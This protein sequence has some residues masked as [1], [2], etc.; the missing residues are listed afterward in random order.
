MDSNYNNG[1][2]VKN[3]DNGNKGLLSLIMGIISILF[4]CGVVGII[5][6]IVAIV[7]GSENKRSDTK[8]K[9]GLV[10]GIIGTILSV[11]G[12]IV[13]IIVWAAAVVAGASNIKEIGTTTNSYDYDLYNYDT[14][15]NS[16]DYNDTEEAYDSTEDNG[17]AT[18][19]DKEQEE[20]V[21][22]TNVDGYTPE[23]D[24]MLIGSDEVGYTYVPSNFI[25]FTEAGGTGFD[26]TVQYAY[27]YEI[28]GLN[29][30]VSEY[31]AY[32]YAQAIASISYSDDAIDQNSITLSTE[33]INGI[34]GYSIMEYYPGDNMFFYF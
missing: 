6:G 4:S 8:A 20:N 28:I 19:A 29:S 30:M 25:S 3:N 34:Y 12:I 17:Y 18:E 14:E 11:I 22:T 7:S 10:L 24:I 1:M 31:D 23:Y 32:T 15:E 26:N 2:D 33:T 9:T 27:G 13:W 16:Y 21:V 5:P